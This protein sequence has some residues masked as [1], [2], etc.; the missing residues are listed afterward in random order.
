[1]ASA[2]SPPAQRWLS[3]SDKIGA[4]GGEQ[5]RGAGPGEAVRGGGAAVEHNSCLCLAR[6]DFFDLG[7][8]VEDWGEG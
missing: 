5:G 1:M 4:G 8:V 7:V 2:V 3:S 6:S